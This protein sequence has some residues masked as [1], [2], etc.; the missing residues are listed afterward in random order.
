MIKSIIAAIALVASSTFAYA[1]TTDAEMKAYAN[2]GVYFDKLTGVMTV[3]GATTQTM[4]GLVMMTLLREDVLVVNMAGP[5][6]DFYAGLS[7]GRS[8]AAEGASVLISEGKECVSACAFAAVGADK[9]S[10]QGKLLFH[11]PYKMGY[12]NNVTLQDVA[13]DAGVAYFDMTRYLVQVKLPLLF[14]REL[15]AGTSPCKFIEVT[16][17]LEIAKLKA[18]ELLGYANYARRYENRCG[19]LNDPFRR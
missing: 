14:A 2:H 12:R 8:I 19:M 16:D 4:S 6:G 17:G 15:L 1:K 11:V 10:I 13:Q 5:G 18:T 9:L 7:I 3:R